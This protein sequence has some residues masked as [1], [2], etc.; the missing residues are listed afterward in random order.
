MAKNVLEVFAQE[1]PHVVADA[2][3]IKEITSYE[4]RW[5][6]SK[7]DNIT[8]FGGVLMGIPKIVFT[9]SDI[10]TWFDDVLQIDDVLLKKELHA[11]PTINKD[12]KVSSDVF[13]LTCFWLLHLI[14]RST[15]IDQKQKHIGCVAVIR[16]MHYRFLTSLMYNYFQF[17]PNRETMEATYAALNNKFSLKQHGS[18]SKLI[19]ARAESI[20]D[21]RGKRYPSIYS[22]DDDKAIVD[23][24]NDIQGRIREVVKKMYAVFLQVHR[25]ASKIQSRSNTVDVE[26]EMHVRDLIR[27]NSQIKQYAH[28]CMTDKRT[29]IRDELVSIILNAVHTMNERMFITTLEYMVDN[30]G[31]R[32][33]SDISKLIDETI[34]HAFDFMNSNREIQRTGTRLATIIT[35]LRA[36]YTSSRST[37]SLLM[38][39]RELSKNIVKRAN[40]T[41]NES[42]I[43]SIRTGVM[44]YI[45]L[46][47]LSMDFYSS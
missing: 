15:K 16:V 41:T 6:N 19:D 13:N 4:R 5:V 36:L 39:M 17:T 44:L 34:L 7:E 38:S 8:F 27:K 24:L 9:P 42:M 29:F 47:S 33:D 32:G 40:K 45:V 25:S 11:L 12:F 43:A 35:R 3:L 18:W 28:E 10:H 46:R 14:I 31:V 30:H 37:E 21:P 23:S 20:L 2:K 22:F 1:A 26:G